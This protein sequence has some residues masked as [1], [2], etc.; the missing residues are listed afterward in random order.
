M[1]SS[2]TS[3]LLIGDVGGT[4]CRFELHEIDGHDY[5]PGVMRNYRTQEV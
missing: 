2:N 4:N 3:Y 1:E 5:K